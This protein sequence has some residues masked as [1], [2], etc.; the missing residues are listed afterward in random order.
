MIISLRENRCK[1]WYV[2]Q[3]KLKGQKFDGYFLVDILLN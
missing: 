1:H 3:V 2:E